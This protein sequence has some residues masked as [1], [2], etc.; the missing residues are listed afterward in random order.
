MWIW[1]PT[2][3]VCPVDIGVGGGGG[4]V[5]EEEEEEE[6]DCRS[7]STKI[8]GFLQNIWYLPDLDRAT[9][10]SDGRE[11]RATWPRSPRTF[12][13]ANRTKKIA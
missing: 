10:R 6:R 8:E 1:R 2:Q 5:E 12:C 3:G 4:D 11:K 13:C 9:A 7:I